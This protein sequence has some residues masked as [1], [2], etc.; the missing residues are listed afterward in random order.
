MML[1]CSLSFVILFF[2]EITFAQHYHWVLFLSVLALK[3]DVSIGRRTGSQ[4]PASGIPV[5]CMSCHDDSCWDC[6]CCCCCSCLG[7]RSPDRDRCLLDLNDRAIRTR[8][9]A[10]RSRSSGL[11]RHRAA[12]APPVSPV[13]VPVD[14]GP[15]RPTDVESPAVSTRNCCCMA[16][17]S[18]TE[19]DLL[20]AA[21]LARN[22]LHVSH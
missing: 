20:Y 8:R 19:W 6:C 10:L 5:P 13:D 3:I 14:C 18:P 15:L 9:T 11:R 2:H 16:G 4:Y 22:T 1:H 21:D 12:A 7:P 17:P